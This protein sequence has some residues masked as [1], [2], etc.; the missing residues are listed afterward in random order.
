MNWYVELVNAV[1]QTEHM[2]CTTRGEAREYARA[3]RGW[4]GIVSVR[5]VDAR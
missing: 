3:V 5:V 4:E 1:G 2:S